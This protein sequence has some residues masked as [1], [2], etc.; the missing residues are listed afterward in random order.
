MLLRYMYLSGRRPTGE[1]LPIWIMTVSISLLFIL[2]SFGVAITVSQTHRLTIAGLTFWLL[3]VTLMS[4]QLNASRQFLLTGQLVREWEYLLCLPL[5]RWQVTIAMLWQWLIS[6]LLLLVTFLL[7]PL[8]AF[9][10]RGALPFEPGPASWGVLLCYLLFTLL[11]GV[12]LHLLRL[13][14]WR[15]VQLLSEVAGTTLALAALWAIIPFSALPLSISPTLLN[16]LQQLARSLVSL[17][18]WPW[19][20]AVAGMQGHWLPFLPLAGITVLL[21]IWVLPRLLHY[22]EI[23]ETPERRAARYPLQLATSD[24]A[25]AKWFCLDLLFSPDLRLMKQFVS[26]LAGFLLLGSLFP[27]GAAGRWLVVLYLATLQPG[28]RAYTYL[29]E[30][31]HA[32]KASGLPVSPRQLLGGFAAAFALI[33]LPFMLLLVVLSMIGGSSPLA[34]IALIPG[35]LGLLALAWCARQEL[36]PQTGFMAMAAFELLA[37][38][39]V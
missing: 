32:L 21:A 13:Q 14:R 6:N 12:G 1:P 23:R 19:V 25:L 26:R 34:I 9:G 10:L 28:W 11:A 39:L 17:G 29:L 22:W 16:T 18:C 20:W 4:M 37:A 7:A 24:W 2:G 15:G 31:S 33:Y 5:A 38:L 8:L 30:Q 3:I 27:F 36:T 35:C